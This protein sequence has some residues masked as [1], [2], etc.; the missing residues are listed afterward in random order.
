MLINAFASARPYL[1]HLTYRDNLRHIREL[2]RLFPASVLMERANRAEFIRS[3][4]RG[5]RQL[6]IDGR[7]ITVRDQDRLHNGNTRLLNGCS[8]EDLIELLNRRVFF[9]PGEAA[10]PISYGRRHF[11]RYEKERPVIIR[12]GFDALLAANSDVVPR[13]CRFNSG[14]PR[15]S[16][17]HRSPRGPETFLLAQDFHETPSK[18]VEVTFDRAI[19]L[20][21]DT[22]CGEAPKG[23]WTQL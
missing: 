19:A 7:V 5:P 9:W 16:N 17:G 12:I 10:G 14:S 15:C 23:P 4:R 22:K 3:L 1:Y 13:F 20:P 21:E 2:G 18:V 8:F 6:S 11:E